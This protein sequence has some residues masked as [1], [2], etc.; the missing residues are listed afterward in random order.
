MAWIESHQNL[1]KH[2]KLFDL[3]AALGWSKAEAIG[4]LHL[5][6]WWCVDHA[7]DGDLRGFHDGHLALAVE[8]DSGDG[9]DFV[10]AMVKAG[11]FERDPYFRVRNWWQYAGNY[12]RRR[13][14]RKPAEWRKVQ[15]AYAPECSTDVVGSTPGSNAGVRNQNRNQNQESPPVSPPAAGGEIPKNV[16]QGKDGRKNRAAEHDAAVREARL[17]VSVRTPRVKELWGMYCAER[18][19]PGKYLTANAVQLLL[20]KFGEY[21]PVAVEKA[22]EESIASGYKGVFP[23]KHEANAATLTIAGGRFEKA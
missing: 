19:R 2:P 13:Y 23:E 14:N 22:L 18:R 16:T 12:L 20:R 5:C 4:R 11:F 9:K 10:S 7:P 6:W 1:E 21:S 15:A 3:M 17:P 8:L